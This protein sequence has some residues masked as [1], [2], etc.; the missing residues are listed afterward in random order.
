M[1]ALSGVIEKSPVDSRS[2]WITDVMSVASCLS[3]PSASKT[4]M[5]IGVGFS[6]PSEMFTVTCAVAAGMTA[7]K[8]ANR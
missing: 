2:F 1:K 7:M 3:A 6:V 4:G 5:A 8:A